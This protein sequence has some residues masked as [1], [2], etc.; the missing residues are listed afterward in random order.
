MLDIPAIIQA[1]PP[2]THL[3][4]CGPAGMLKAFA[5]A[6]QGR[7]PETV[8]LEYFTT[9]VAPAQQG[10]FEVVLARS[11]KTITIAPGQ[12]ILEAVLALGMNVPR[13][14]TQ[15]VCG[16]CETAVI[17][18]MPDHRDTV[19][20]ARERASNKKM[21]ICCSGCLSERLVLDL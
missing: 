20:S 18:G 10:G 11:G 17:E 3:Y 16:T 13:S 21:M 19:L 12:T 5:G 2:D 1:Q 9:N 8:H 6:A 7:P 15:G 4:C 14:C